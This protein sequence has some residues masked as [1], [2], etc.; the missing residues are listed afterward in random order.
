MKIV[1]EGPNNVGKS[2][3]IARLKECEEFKNF[4]IEHV[5][6]HCPND[7]EFHETL[8]NMPQDMIFD[9][10]YIGET[11]Y[12]A[13]FNR[14]SKMSIKQLIDIC[15]QH[16]DD[17]IIF[18]IDADCGF[19]D[20]AYMKKDEQVDWKFVYKEKQMFE[21]RY[22][23]LRASGINIFKVKNHFDTSYTHEFTRDDAI[24]AAIDFYNSLK[25]KE[26]V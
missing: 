17:T 23:T 12:P 19:I 5:D 25:I 6:S 13:L 4:E 18:V 11:I 26:E 9:R 22:K 10:F 21:E 7:Y 15:K 3:F 1:I 20:R 24:Q 8:L 16:N 2:T 14:E